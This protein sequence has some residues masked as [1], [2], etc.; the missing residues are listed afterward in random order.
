MPKEILTP[1][2]ESELERER[3]KKVQPIL[4]CLPRTLRAT[5]E[6][7]E[8][9]T[10]RL[11]VRNGGGGTLAWTVGFSPSWARVSPESGEL[12][13]GESRRLMV[14]VD[15]SR[16]REGRTRGQVV[17]EAAGAKGSPASV[18]ATARVEAPPKPRAKVLPRQKVH[19]PE[20][21]REGPG[22]VGADF[23]I[24]VGIGGSNPDQLAAGVEIPLAG[25]L[26]VWGM[27]A[28]IPEERVHYVATLRWYICRRQKYAS[29]VC[30]GAFDRTHPVEPREAGPTGGVGVMFALEGNLAVEMGVGYPG[31]GFP[32]FEAMLGLR[33]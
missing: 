18:P 1:E 5:L 9:T 12:G 27:Y 4:V 32:W 22:L 8:T 15:G 21:P 33:F 31:G 29:Y 17:I 10:L 3:V 2:E 25:Q 13:P 19:A 14:V 11:T 23:A 20:R 26:S 7:G 30:V 6:P 16:L 28:S 24:L